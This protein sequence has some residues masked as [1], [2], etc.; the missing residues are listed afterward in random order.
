MSFEPTSPESQDS[1]RQDPTRDPIYD[2]EIVD[3]SGMHQA[4]T[5]L[6]D[7]LPYTP[8]GFND[9]YEEAKWLRKLSGNAAI[10]FMLIFLALL[11]AGAYADSVE[12]R[13]LNPKL[14]ATMMDSMAKDTTSQEA[15]DST[16]RAIV[17]DM[18]DDAANTPLPGFLERFGLKI[19]SALGSI[20]FFVFASAAVSE[21]SFRAYEG[22]E[23]EP[24]DVL[25][26]LTK[27]HGMKL[28]QLGGFFL[29]ILL[30]VGATTLALEAADSKMAALLGFVILFCQLYFQLRMCFSVQVLIGEDLSPKEAIIRSWNLT[31]GNLLRLLWW[32]ILFG[33]LFMLIAFFLY[34]VPIFI[35]V[36][37]L[38]AT[39]PWGLEII[40]IIGSIVALALMV[41]HFSLIFFFQMALYRELRLRRDGIDPHQPQ[42]GPMPVVA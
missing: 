16:M 30:L 35:I 4:E 7:N 13:R 36:G 15:Q 2:A 25:D 6:E 14:F 19:L 1:R 33:L 5:R 32:S 21:I 26:N 9:V 28:L 27:S 37:V 23:I 18:S 38:V 29:A 34:M 20:G 39:L 10:A 22:R 40:A 12:L 24:Y 3:L 8:K 41:K 11:S 31:K 17:K 42:A